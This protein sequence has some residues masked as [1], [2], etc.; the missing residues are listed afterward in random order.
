MVK[1]SDW[2]PWRYGKHNHV[3]IKLAVSILL[4]G[5]AFRLFSSTSSGSVRV[6]EVRESNLSFPDGYAGERSD[7]QEPDLGASM[8]KTNK[9]RGGEWSATLSTGLSR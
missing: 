7:T 1:D 8:T 6:S 3:I 2:N 4:V 5:L 9:S